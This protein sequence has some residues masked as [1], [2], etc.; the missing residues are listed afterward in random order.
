MGKGGGLSGGGG[1]T[2]FKRKEKVYPP[3]LLL[4]SYDCEKLSKLAKGMVGSDNQT[5]WELLGYTKV[6]SAS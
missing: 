4:I 2:I 3:H 5:S 1:K 6:R